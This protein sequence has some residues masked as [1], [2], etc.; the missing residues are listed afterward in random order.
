[1]LR[2]VPQPG[3]A[4]ERVTVSLKNLIDLAKPARA[5]KLRAAAARA[6]QNGE[7]LSRHKGRGMAFAETRLYQPGDDVRRIDWRVTARTG[8]PHSKIFLEERE[9]PMLISVDYRQTMHF[10]TRG[11]F[12]SVLAARLAGMLAWMALQQ[13]D[14]IGGQIFSEQ[15]CQEL[16]PLSGQAAMLHFFHALVAPRYLGG[17]QP[18]LEQSL[19]RLQQH[20]RPGARIVIL[21][22]FRG[23]NPAAE[24]HLALLGRHCDVILL[25]IADPLETQLPN[26]G[27]YRFTDNLREIFID[28]GDRKFN[29]EY[30]QRFEQRQQ[31]LRELSRRFRLTWLSCATTQTP[32][33]ILQALM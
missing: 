14:R 32:V 8:K 15:G 19:A 26:K 11:L 33:E 23:L 29:R 27:Y 10:A 25:Q 5:L 12:K 7:Y 3:A 21:S 2:T 30:R 31:K 28:G 24:H 22:D 4:N 6:A 20:A 9:R 17:P 1:M 16:K 13:G 18:G